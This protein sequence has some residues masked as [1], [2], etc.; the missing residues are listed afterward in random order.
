MTTT[1]FK[2]LPLSAEFLANLQSLEYKAMTPI[3]AQSLPE[4]LKG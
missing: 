1:A 4:I 2:S 3:Q